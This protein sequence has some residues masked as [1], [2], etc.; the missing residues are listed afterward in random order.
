MSRETN[1]G[2]P[3]LRA[4]LEEL[5]EMAPPKPDGKPNQS[6]IARQTGVGQQNVNTAFRRKYFNPKLESLALWAESEGRPAWQIVRRIEARYG[7][8]VSPIA[9][10][11]PGIEKVIEAID[12]GTEKRSSKERQRL[13]EQL[14]KSLRACMRLGYLDL[15][16]E[17][18]AALASQGP[19]GSIVEVTQTLHEG[20]SD[21]LAAQKRARTKFAKDY[22]KIS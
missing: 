5:R 16:V 7:G 21:D 20:G 2:L 12:P 10:G 9:Q 11:A 22:E 18:L 3:L 1:K 8:D 15:V 17:I 6:E 14:D 19:M 4:A 13:A